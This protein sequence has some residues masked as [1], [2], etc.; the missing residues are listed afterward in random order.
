MFL[1]LLTTYYLLLECMHTDISYKYVKNAMVLV[2]NITTTTKDREAQNKDGLYWNINILIV[3]QTI[4]CTKLEPYIGNRNFPSIL[5]S[6]IKIEEMEKK[7][8]TV[9]IKTVVTLPNFSLVV[10]VLMRFQK[11]ELV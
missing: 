5:S 2:M 7:F 8:T 4:T 10:F 3:H 11:L 6:V 1:L 9:Y